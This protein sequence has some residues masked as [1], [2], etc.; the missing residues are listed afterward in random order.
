[1]F[2]LQSAVLANKSPPSVTLAGLEE[3]LKGFRS[4]K[5]LA[6]NFRVAHGKSA[7]ETFF[8]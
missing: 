7:L 6:L 2:E 5:I 3:L 8:I 1:M 4:D